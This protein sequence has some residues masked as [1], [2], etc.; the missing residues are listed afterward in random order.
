VAVKYMGF[1]TFF[2]VFNETKL[3]NNGTMFMQPFLL[4]KEVTF[5]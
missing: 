2:A 4:N 1:I 5:H 3:K